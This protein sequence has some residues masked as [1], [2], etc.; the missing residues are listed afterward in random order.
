MRSEGAINVPLRALGAIGTWGSRRATAWLG[1]ESLRAHQ[2]KLNA[3]AGLGRRADKEHQPGDAH[4]V[5]IVRLHLVSLL[6]CGER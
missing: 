4:C 5:P 2:L 3:S 6:G 1:F